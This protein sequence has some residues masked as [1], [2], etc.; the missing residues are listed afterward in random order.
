MEDKMSNPVAR[1]FT[2]SE[3]LALPENRMSSAQSNEGEALAY[4]MS[5]GHLSV[6]PPRLVMLSCWRVMC[7]MVHAAA[8]H[9]RMAAALVDRL[10][11]RRLSSPRRRHPQ[12][13]RC[14][15]YAQ[16]VW[17][18]GTTGGLCRLLVGASRS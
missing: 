13:L 2:Q 5:K 15:L 14:A 1:K 11:M 12:K 8:V 6:P 3:C 16:V 18:Q 17:R 7:S 10:E 9:C 4:R